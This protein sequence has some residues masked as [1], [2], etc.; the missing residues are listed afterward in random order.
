M[1]AVSVLALLAAGTYALRLAGPAFHHRLHLS[2]GAEWLL[3]GIATVL[4]TAL[5]VTSALTEGHGFADWARPL[6]VAVGAVL[7][8]RRL[9]LPVVVVAAAATTALLRTAGLH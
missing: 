8:V 1:N 6:G 9:P 5:A 7:A 2:A 4:L 3:G